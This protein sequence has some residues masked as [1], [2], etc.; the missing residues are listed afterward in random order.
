VGRKSTG[1]AR[2]N[3]RAMR[4]AVRDDV[5]RVL[6]PEQVALR[7]EQKGIDWVESPL[8]ARLEDRSALLST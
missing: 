6:G 3:L 7:R 1:C 5:G 2:R 8:H 4:I